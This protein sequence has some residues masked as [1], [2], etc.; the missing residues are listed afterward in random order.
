MLG[1]AA[2]DAGWHICGQHIV[3]RSSPVMVLVDVEGP[4]WSG[5][6]TVS[7]EFIRLIPLVM[8]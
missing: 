4:L 8:G 2:V 6:A 1:S 3:C 7:H 5:T